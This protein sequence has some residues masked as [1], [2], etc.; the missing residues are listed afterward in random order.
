MRRSR[1]GIGLQWVALAGIILQPLPMARSYWTDSDGNGAKDWVADP[2][3]GDPWFADNSDGDGMTNEEEVLFGSDPYRLDSDLDGMT[4]KDERDLTLAMNGYLT[5]TDPWSWD[6]DSD[7][8]SDHDEYYAWLQG[9]SP[10]V[11]YNNLPSGPSWSGGAFFTYFDADGDGIHNQDD[12]EPVTM[13]RDNDGIPN[14]QDSYMDDHWNGG[15]DP[16]AGGSGGSGSGGTDPGVIIGGT[17]YPSG[18]LDGDNDGI[19][20]HMDPYPSGSYFYNGSEY[21]GAWSDRDWDGIPDGPDPFPDGSYTFNG[22]EYGGV[23]VD[24]DNDGVPDPAD[25]WPSVL[26]SFWYEGVEY[27]GSWQDADGDGIPDFM[28]SWPNSRWNG[29]PS[30]FYNGIEYGGAW[31]DRDA[32]GV[33]DPADNWQDDP[34]NGIDS[35]GDGLD[36]YTERTLHLTDPYQVDSD[37]DFL[38]DYEELY[39]FHTLPLLAISHPE[40]G[41]TLLDGYLHM[42]VDSDGDE[43]PDLIEDHYASLGFGLD[44]TNPAD[45]AGDLDGDGITNLRA[46]HY[47]WDLVAQLDQYDADRDGITDAREDAWAAMAIGTVLEGR[48]N[49]ALFADAVEDPDGDG[50]FN[51]EESAR[52][53]DPTDAHSYCSGAT[54]GQIGAWMR[55]VYRPRFDH[56]TDA[57][58]NPIHADG[59][60]SL[61][62]VEEDADQDNLPDGYE[63]WVLNAQGGTPPPAT[64]DHPT[65]QDGDGMDDI[66]EYRHQLDLR[67]ILDSGSWVAGLVIHPVTSGGVPDAAAAEAA[68]IDPDFDG[69]S[70]WRE[71]Q[72]GTNPRIQDTDGDGVGDALEL[73]HNTAPTSRSSLPPLVLTALGATSLNVATGQ[74]LSAPLTVRAT[75][76]GVPMPQVPVVFTLLSGGGTLGG[77]GGTY[78]THTNASGVAAATFVTPVTPG[79]SAITAQTQSAPPTSWSVTST[80]NPGPT[81]DPTPDPAP[82]PTPQPNFP[83]SAQVPAILENQWMISSFEDALEWNNLEEWTWSQSGSPLV[84]SWVKTWGGQSPGERSQIGIWLS[85]GGEGGGN[86]SAAEASIRVIPVSIAQG[87][88]WEPTPF[89]LQATGSWTTSLTSTGGLGLPPNDPGTNSGDTV[90]RAHHARIGET[91]GGIIRKI[92]LRRHPGHDPRLTFSRSFIKVVEITGQPTTYEAVTLTIQPGQASSKPII[93]NGMASAHGQTRSERLLPIEFEVKHTEIDPATGQVVNP[94]ANTMLRDEIVDIKIKVPPIGTTDWTV[95]LSVEPQ[96]MRNESLPNRGNVQMYD[97]GQV[98]TDGT[99]TPDKTQFVLQASAGGERTIKAVFN[100]EGTLKIKM[101]STDGKIDFTSP[102]YTIQKRMR[103]YASLPSSQS[104]DLNQHDKAFEDAAKHWGGVYQHQ[105]DDVE[106]LKAMGMA[107]SEL[108]LTDATDILTVGNPGDHVL[109]TFRNVAPYDRLPGVSPL[110]GLALREVDI[111]NNT[112][113]MLSYPAADETPAA[114]AIHWGVCW[115]YQKA[116][117]IQ[118]NPNPPQPPNPP[119][120]YVPGPWRSWDTAT[121]RYNGGGVPNYLQRINRSMKEGRH[122]SNANLY[123]WP[124]KSNKKARGNQ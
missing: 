22:V 80:Q 117:S 49:K 11:N 2:P 53:W 116:S 89:P 102:D 113:R 25:P 105:V 103:K 94:G 110:G 87:L 77:Q 115:L 44:K 7:G 70:N 90:L 42:G 119:N 41:Q 123:I 32:D 83:A 55:D 98:E 79:T 26:G 4:D 114:T 27:P 88:Q 124:L 121:E 72:F 16:N 64:L 82:T 109:D 93:L 39:V 122:P 63:Y 8:F 78:T 81:P 43:L 54:D 111:A 10:M 59:V 76:A 23:W 60:G 6:S 18:T 120:P 36:N 5:T 1:L 12:M 68:L 74:P 37:N 112:T 67:D 38:T 62:R 84:W 106:R 9:S 40:R 14:W 61:Y 107:E 52:D 57:M 97:F 45:A 20:D 96:A 21:G 19:P 48:F 101:K 35:D 118:N 66:W 51:F 92:R 86:G 85:N 100:K 17:W 15:G 24:Q 73:L 104:H 29:E 99:V 75:R 91:Y 108:G 13:D 50:L 3:A 58:G 65:D 33:P 95:D 46:Y 31:V 69:L 47:G 30:Y 56:G 28:D 71:Y 34:E